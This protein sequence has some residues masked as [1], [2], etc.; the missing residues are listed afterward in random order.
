MKKLINEVECEGLEK[1]LGEKVLL[2][3]INYFY[4]GNLIGVN[5]QD[6]LLED[7]HIVYETG[8]WSDSGFT[9]SQKVA[10]EMY[11]RISAI[12]SYAVKS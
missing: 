6:V 7:A 5:D 9:D 12:E 1:L 10:E 11:V 3:C 4:H 8:S 2:L